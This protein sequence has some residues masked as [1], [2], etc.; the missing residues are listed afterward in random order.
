[1][2]Q[3]GNRKRDTA[4]RRAAVAQALAAQ[5]AKQR[6][7]KMIW[8][9]VIGVLVVALL[10]GIAAA[11]LVGR[12]A[13]KIAG[14]KTFG[15]LSQNHVTT[16][17]VYPQNPP[18]GG[19]HNAVFLNCG[20]YDA[21]VANE[22]AVHSL[23][24]GAV[25]ITYRTGLPA[26]Q[27]AQLKAAVAGKAYTLLSPIADLPHPV[28]ASAWSTQLALDSAGDARLGKFIAK[29]MGGS[30]APEPGA[31]CSGGTGTPTG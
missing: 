23:E 16:P 2:T 8:N 7:S 30:Q 24:H 29:Y 11:A 1:M 14:V 26:D 27:I 18:V 31:P 3:T 22:N 5:K 10:G 13:G 21:P 17:V 28:V 12:N 25:W 15:K 19:D 20:V 6:R 9:T 4:E